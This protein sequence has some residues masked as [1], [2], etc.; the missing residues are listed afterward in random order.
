MTLMNAQHDMT[1]LRHLPKRKKKGKRKERK[2]AICI[3][4]FP[5]SSISNTT[6]ADIY[7]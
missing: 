6:R 2:D 5:S 3:C 7:Q 4:I 1:S